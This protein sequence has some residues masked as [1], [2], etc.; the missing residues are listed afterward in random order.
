MESYLKDK[1]DF[2]GASLKFK[3]RSNTLP[4]DNRLSSWVVD[5]DG[6]CT[7]CNN[8]CEDTKHFMLSCQ[9][10]RAIRD[11]ELHKLQINLRQSGFTYVWNFF[12]L[13]DNDIK[14]CLML[15]SKCMTFIPMTYNTSHEVTID[16]QFDIFC[17]SYLKRAWSCRTVLKNDQVNLVSS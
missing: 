6:T 4:L 14:L 16:A 7:L 10:L 17:K 3:A 2:Y 1:L 8:G 13:S 9:S 11:N 12:T 15:G 5:N